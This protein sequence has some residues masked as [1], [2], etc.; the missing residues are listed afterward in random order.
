MA[1]KDHFSPKHGL[2]GMSTLVRMDRRKRTTATTLFIF[3]SSGA[4]ARVANPALIILWA[5]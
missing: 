1:T 3:Q 4:P 5:T 2:D